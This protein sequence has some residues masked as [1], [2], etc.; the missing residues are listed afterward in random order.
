MEGRRRRQARRPDGAPALRDEGRGL[1]RDEVWRRGTTPVRFLPRQV[2]HAVRGLQVLAVLLGLFSGVR[3]LRAADAASQATSRPAR[4][5]N[6]LFIIIDDVAA[7]L[8]SVNGHDG[9]LRTPNIE[10]IASRGTWFTRAYNDA[11]ACCPSRTALVTGVHSA[12]SGVYYNTQGYR[13]AKTPIANV[14][15]LPGSFLRHGYLT[16]SFGKFIHSG[17]QADDASDYT[18]GYQKMHGRK[19]HVTHTDVA[20]LKHVIPGSIREIPGVGNWTW[21]I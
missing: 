2:R 21:G 3:V 19:E 9:P 7:N 8:H 15:S 5:L 13:R 11:P 14:Q 12:K 20:L 17:F 16:A 6:V 18:P 1:V 10:R 4:P